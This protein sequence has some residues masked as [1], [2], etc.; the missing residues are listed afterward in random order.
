MSL[1]QLQGGTS[2]RLGP[3]FCRI[4]HRRRHGLRG[5]G[6]PGTTQGPTDLLGGNVTRGEPI[7]WVGKVGNCDICGT[8]LN[9]LPSFADCV[10]DRRSWMWG[11][12]CTYCLEAS[13]LEIAPGL[14][15]LF[16]KSQDRYLLVLNETVIHTQFNASN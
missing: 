9:A 5:Q 10:I 16:Q 3:V 7:Y 13:G 8:D 6:W 2:E 11:L 1:W 15:Q 4:Y 12:V 14:G